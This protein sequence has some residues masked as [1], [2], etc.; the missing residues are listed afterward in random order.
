MSCKRLTLFVCMPILVFMLPVALA[1]QQTNCDAGNGAMN[2]AQPQGISVQ[3]LIQKF[4]GKEGVFKDARNNYTYTQEILVQTVDGDTVD[5]EFR[6]TTDILYDDKGKRIEKVT[7][8]PQ[9]TL[10]RVGMT[11]EDFDD[12][13]NRLP[14]VLTA[15]DLGNYNILYVGQ[16]LVDELDTYV[17]DIAPKKVDKNG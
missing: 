10:T 17:F 13:R 14:F 7:F 9:S 2:P 11:R 4:A 5:G 8:A 16:Q 1:A 6:Q 3:E 15:Q 12:F